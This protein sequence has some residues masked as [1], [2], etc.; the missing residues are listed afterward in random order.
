LREI[1]A[2]FVAAA[3]EGA[4][5]RTRLRVSEQDAVV[6]EALGSYLGQLAGRDL[7]A[8][9][10]Q[11]RLDA[12]GRA[13]SRRERKRALT[14]AS[15]S[16]W[17]GT[18]TRGSEDSWRLAERNLQEEAGSL[19]ARVRRVEARLNQAERYSKQRRL[20]VLR[21]RLA[22]VEERVAAGRVSVCRGGR[23]LARARQN[24]EAAGTSLAEWRREWG[25]E[26]LFICA[27]GDAAA[28]L[29]NYTITWHPGER[30][31]EVN[32]PDPLAHLANAPAG[33]YRL[34]CE[35]GFPHRGGEVAAQAETGA[36]RYDI[37]FDPRRSRWYLAASW[38]VSPGPS[39]ALGDLRCAPVL[40]ADL[41]HGHL[42]ALV[43]LPDGNPAGHAHTVPLELDGLPAA[44]PTGG[45]AP[46]SPR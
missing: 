20:Q 44:Q 23:R 9:C 31:L 7:A 30:Y 45:S 32:L 3:P 28:P 22:V 43:V 4:R 37:S 15:S 2:P 41:N 25:A 19:R 36:V 26:R 5:V 18:I 42:A 17:A 12:R 33:R 16:R 35:A 1:R 39:P 24:L 13:V 46:P 6:L 21:A 27:D 40:A 11:G 38:R 14:G 10:A 34:N 8:R 29:G